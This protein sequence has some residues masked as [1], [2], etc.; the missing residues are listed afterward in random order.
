M[1]KSNKKLWL[2]LANNILN[3]IILLSDANVFLNLWQNKLKK[4][5]LNDIILMLSMAIGKNVLN[6]AK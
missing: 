5:T 2:N 1:R 3:N 4:I 6:A